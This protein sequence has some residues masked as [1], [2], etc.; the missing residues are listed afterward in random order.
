[1]VPIG[2]GDGLRRRRVSL[3]RLGAGEQRHRHL[4]FHEGTVEPP[5]TDAAAVFEHALGAEIAAAGHARIDTG[6]FS[7]AALAKPV[8]IPGRLRAFL[9]IDHKID[10]D[11]RSAGPVGVRRCGTVADKIAR[12]GFSAGSG[13]QSSSRI[14]SSE[15]GHSAG[16]RSAALCS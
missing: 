3:E 14:W 6:R 7:E 5:P 1:D 4:V 13:Y 10:R 12:H 8:D 15:Y 9:E 11:L 2:G 16:I